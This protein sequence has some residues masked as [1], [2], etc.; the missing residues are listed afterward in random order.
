MVNVD[1]Q[2]S[3]QKSNIHT[4]SHTQMT[5]HTHTHTHTHIKSNRAESESYRLKK[6]VFRADL[7]VVI[8]AAF[9]VAVSS[10]QKG[11]NERRHDYLSSFIYIHEPGCL[12]KRL[13]CCHQGLCK[14]S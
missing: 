6:C 5:T 2:K 1:V 12:A 13:F 3:K 14:G 11:Q 7:K 9:V 8:V 10:G 4:E